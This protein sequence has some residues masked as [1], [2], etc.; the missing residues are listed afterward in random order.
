M[1][2]RLGGKA[3]VVDIAVKSARAFAAQLELLF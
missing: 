2:T 3:P 1:P